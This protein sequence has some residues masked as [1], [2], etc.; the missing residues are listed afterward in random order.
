M[1]R[2]TGF[3]FLFAG[4]SC[5]SLFV[6]RFIFSPLPMNDLERTIMLD[7]RLPRI[8]V[9]ALIGASLSTAGLAFQNT[10]RNPLAGPNVLGVTSGSAF[11]AVVAILLFTS[12]PALI[13]LMAFL[14]GILAVALVLY[15]SRLIGDGILSLVL[16]GMAVSAFFSALVG[17]AKYMADPYDKLPTIVFWLLGSLAGMRWESTG[18]LPVPILIGI[19][20]LMLLRWPLNVLSLGEEEAKALGLNVKAYRTLII[21]LSTLCIS[22][23]TAMAGIV[24]WVGLIAPHMARLLVGHDARSL[25]PASALI[26]ATLLIVCDDLARSLAPM[27]LPLGVMTSII[28]APA[29]VIILRRRWYAVR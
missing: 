29:L 8:V 7:V 10:F 9:G 25:V 20:G 1:K 28:G 19:G 14:G 11:G 27:E 22:A 13:Q 17:V 4:V 2:L 21:M 6:G 26:G 16:A 12:N 5:I 23:S 24:S 15:L 18:L 3:L